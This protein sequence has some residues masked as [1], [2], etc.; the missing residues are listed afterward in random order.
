MKFFGVNDKNHQL[1]AVGY[2]PI[3]GVL[4]VRFKKGQGEHR[5]VPENVFES[6]K[7][8]PFAYSYYTKVVKGKYS[9][10]R[11]EDPPEEPNGSRGSN[12][13]DVARRDSNGRSERTDGLDARQDRNLPGNGETVL[14]DGR[15]DAQGT[16]GRAMEFLREEDG[17]KFVEEGHRYELNGKRLISLTQILDAAGL[18]DYSMVQPDVL[19]AKA[20]FGTKVHEYTKWHDQGELEPADLETL[21]AHPKY[22]PRITGW[23]QFLEDFHFAP[24]LNWCEVPCAV[25]LN[26]M[27][28]AMTIDRFGIMGT[29][30]EIVAGKGI[31]AIV[32]IKTCA[33]HQPS[34]QIQTAGQAVIFR[35][36]G[37]VPL[38]RYGVYLLDKPKADGRYYR[39]EE[40]TDRMDEKVFV[41]SL[42][43]VQYRINNGLLK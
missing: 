7:R 27:M 40:H 6:L 22:G 14:P 35:G 21:K 18:V 36:D 26:G 11:I 5:G 37:S 42:M 41:A 1:L 16:G 38:K 32:E 33:D 4:G 30:E 23:L 9:Y 24:D 12:I 20:A 25:K 3:D 29:K 17:L 19:A 15:C 28:F 8:V 10:T 13:Q 31:M 43:L 39:A 2:E 34:H